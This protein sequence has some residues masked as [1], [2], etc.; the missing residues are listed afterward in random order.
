MRPE[1]GARTAEPDGAVEPAGRYGIGR[2]LRGSEGRS[3]RK[4]LTATE[5]G[6]CESA[7][8]ALGPRRQG[9]LPGLA[10]GGAAGW[11]HGGRDPCPSLR[12][13]GAAGEERAQAPS[14]WLRRRPDPGGSQTPPDTQEGRHRLVTALAGGTFC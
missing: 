14:K 3:V 12:G 2:G 1:H 5:A 8:V 11:A 9:S 13:E 6:A 7:V 4:E 10:R